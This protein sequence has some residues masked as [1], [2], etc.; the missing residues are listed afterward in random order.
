MA[1]PER[2]T[3]VTPPVRGSAAPS[4]RADLLCQAKTARVNTS[5]RRETRAGWRA[6]RKRTWRGKERTHWRTGTASSCCKQG[7]SHPLIDMLYDSRVLH[8]VRR[9]V[10]G[11]DVAG[12]RFNA[13]ALDFGCYVDLFNTKKAPAG[14]FASEDEAGN[15]VY[16]EVPQDDYRSIRRAILDLSR[17]EQHLPKAR[18]VATR[19]RLG[20]GVGNPAAGRWAASLARTTSSSAAP[21]GTCAN[22]GELQAPRASR[23]GA[24]G[25]LRCWWITSRPGTKGGCAGGCLGAGQGLGKVLPRRTGSCGYPLYGPRLAPAC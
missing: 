11:R 17:F 12:V 20:G 1:L 25:S 24:S 9:G 21:G 3:A 8:V 2:W 15:E 14:L 4:R 10:S 23:T 16:A 6:A 13:Y 18:D 7:E 5:S 19:H 22:R